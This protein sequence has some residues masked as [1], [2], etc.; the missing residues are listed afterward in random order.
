MSQS[1]GSGESFKIFWFRVC[2]RKACGC[3]MIDGLLSREDECS[4]YCRTDWQQLLWQS[5]FFDDCAAV[6]KE[7]K[8]CFGDRPVKEWPVYGCGGAVQNSNVWLVSF[9]WYN[10]FGNY[11]LIFFLAERPPEVVKEV[12]MNH[13]HAWCNAMQKVTQEELNL[14]LPKF[15]AD[16]DWAIGAHLGLRM[17]YFPWNEHQTQRPSLTLKG[18]GVLF[19]CVA[20]KD[21][22]SLAPIWAMGADM[23]YS[24]EKYYNGEQLPKAENYETT[25]RE[26]LTR[27]QATLEATLEEI[28]EGTLQATLEATLEAALS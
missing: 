14:H 18:W 3:F 17:G 7:A 27:I 10:P 9:C 11:T 1:A 19:M 20:R 23:F 28:L 8:A 22:E 12:I 21:I 26:N 25:G 2:N 16:P 24:T 6:M 4:P 15:Y 5:H 13:Q